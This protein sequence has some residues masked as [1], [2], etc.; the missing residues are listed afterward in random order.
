[1]LSHT[2]PFQNIVSVVHRITKI[3]IEL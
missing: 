3:D 1:M 2:L